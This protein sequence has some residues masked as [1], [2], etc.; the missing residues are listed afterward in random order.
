MSAGIDEAVTQGLKVCEELEG[1]A[2]D[3]CAIQ[4]L[5]GGTVGAAPT[6]L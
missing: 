3:W 2:R 4:A 1:T 6:R 5:D